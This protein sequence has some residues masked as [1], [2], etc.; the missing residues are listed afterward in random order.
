MQIKKWMIECL[1]IVFMLGLFFILNVDQKDINAQ[2]VEYLKNYSSPTIQLQENDLLS[3]KAFIVSELH[4]FKQNSKIKYDFL[5]YLN[6]EKN[7]TIHLAEISF[8]SGYLLNEY[9]KTG[10]EDLLNQIFSFYKGSTFCTQEEYQFYQKLYHYNKNLN[11]HEKIRIL[12][13]DI[14]H[15]LDSAI[16]FFNYYMKEDIKDIDSI[17]NLSS[18]DPLLIH[19][20][21]NIIASKSFYE[22]L[23][24]QERDLAMYQN[25]LFLQSYYDFDGFYAQLGA[26]HGFSDLLNDQF[27]SFTYF[28]NHDETSPVNNAVISI[29]IFYKD[30]ECLEIYSIKSTFIYKNEKIKKTYKT[31]NL[32][33]FS[34]NLVFIHLNGNDSPFNK[35][36]VWYHQRDNDCEKVTTDYYQYMLIINHSKAA[37]PIDGKVET[38]RIDGFVQ[39]IKKYLGF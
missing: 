34:K 2:E 20:K 5:T 36:L 37:T 4:G 31:N 32:D 27:E 11:E 14:E 12:G 23:N 25:Y 17:I 28:L 6:E 26:K 7:I 38:N 8:S 35:H 30:S 39:L 29:M 16:Y 18:N 10:D 21:N 24:W 3:N 1:V 19:I 33:V 9:L 13:I 15:S 22:N